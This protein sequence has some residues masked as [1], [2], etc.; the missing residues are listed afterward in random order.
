MKKST[1]NF[2]MMVVGCTLKK[3]EVEPYNLEDPVVFALWPCNVA[4]FAVAQ[5]PG[6][7]L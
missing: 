5:E 1:V 3:G 2:A 4:M 6:V 7:R